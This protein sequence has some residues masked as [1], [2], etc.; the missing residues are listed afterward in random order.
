MKSSPARYSTLD[1]GTERPRVALIVRSASG[2][3][4]AGYVQLSP[5]LKPFDA[6][7]SELRVVQ[8]PAAIRG[9]VIGTKGYKIRTL[10]QRHGV[11]ISID[12]QSGDP[13]IG[14]P[15]TRDDWFTFT[16]TAR[17]ITAAVA[18]LDALVDTVSKRRA[19][20][21]GH[22]ETRGRALTGT[23]LRH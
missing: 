1:I 15:H 17:G 2:D 18:E 4:L 7:R 13:G 5:Q 21:K 23:L 8:I 12:R 10:E 22:M 19:R 3:R 14:A 6:D 9:Q 20:E 16:G 11:R